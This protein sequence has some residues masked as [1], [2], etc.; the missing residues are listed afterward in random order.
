MVAQPEI[1]GPGRLGIYFYHLLYLLKKDSELITEI[2]YKDTA[3]ANLTLPRLSIPTY[4]FAATS[5]RNRPNS[6]TV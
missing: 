5:L 3:S 4:F 2:L 6:A 1:M